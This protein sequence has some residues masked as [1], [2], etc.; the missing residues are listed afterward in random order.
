MTVLDYMVDIPARQATWL[1]G[2]Y[3]NP[4]PELTLSPQSGTMNSA[5]ASISSLS[6]VEAIVQKLLVGPVQR[7]A[8]RIKLFTTREGWPV[9]LLRPTNS[10]FGFGTG[11]NQVKMSFVPISRHFAKNTDFVQIFPPCTFDL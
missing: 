6:S 9:G 3:D 11:L 8:D 1:A 4:M 5:T 7:W 10:G 2:R